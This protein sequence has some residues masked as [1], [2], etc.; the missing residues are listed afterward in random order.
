MTR[1]HF[2]P[3]PAIDRTRNRWRLDKIRFDYRLHL[4]VDRHHSSPTAQPN[5]G[6]QAGLFRDEDTAYTAVVTQGTRTVL[7]VLPGVGPQ[8]TARGFSATAFA[9]VE[10]P[11]VLE[12]ATLGLHM[13]TDTYFENRTWDNVHWW[14]ARG[15]GAPMI[16]APGAFHAAHI[17][18]RWGAAGSSLRS[19]YPEIDGTGSPIQERIQV[20]PNCWHQTIKVA[21]TQHIPQFD[22][23]ASGVT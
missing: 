13:G 23:T 8:F 4:F 14:G 2:H 18:W 10:K 15:A 19:S 17:H 20:D 21:T 3:N 1:F 7:R 9:A 22:P 6:N 11:L 5:I 12:V 16:S